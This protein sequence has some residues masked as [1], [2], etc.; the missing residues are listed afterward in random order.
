M[1]GE[2]RGEGHLA[3]LSQWRIHGR[4]RNSSEFDILGHDSE[5]LAPLDRQEC[6][7]Y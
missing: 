5:L 1:R 6:L 7:Y 2:G 4:R 3:L